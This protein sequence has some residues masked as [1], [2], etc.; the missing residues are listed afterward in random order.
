MPAVVI[1]SGASGTKATST[2]QALARDIADLGA[3]VF[4]PDFPRGDARRM[5]TQDNATPLREAM[6]SAACAIR[7]ARANVA[8]YGG[9][10]DQVLVIGLSAG[11]A[12]GLWAALIGDD[13]AIVWDEITADRGTPLPQ[14]DCVASEGS[15]RPDAFV[16]YGG[17]YNI[18]E[19]VRSQDPE[20]ATVMLPETYIGANTDVTLRFI[21]GTMDTTVPRPLQEQ[22]EALSQT[23]AEAGYDSTWTTVEAGHILSPFLPAAHEAIVAAVAEI[24]D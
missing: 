22:H 8:E 2:Y 23:L 4:I 16:G 20:L 5:F 13:L 15:I 17:G 24:L 14:L 6:E 12:L 18:M 7:F 3:V 1:L 19:L 21:N 10:S 11:G 9:S